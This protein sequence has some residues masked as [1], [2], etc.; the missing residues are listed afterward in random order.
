MLSALKMK[1][2]W[3]KWLFYTKISYTINYYIYFLKLFF[4]FSSWFSI[5]PCHYFFFLCFFFSLEHSSFS[6]LKTTEPR[7]QT[8][9]SHYFSHSFF[10]F[11]LL[12]CLL[13]FHYQ[14]LLTFP[15]PHLHVAMVERYY[16]SLFQA[17]VIVTHYDRF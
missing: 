2:S 13:T 11:F 5:F 10:F 4:L 7:S 17:I 14:W 6:L 8:L 15:L 16:C 9:I 3:P 1:F 12:L